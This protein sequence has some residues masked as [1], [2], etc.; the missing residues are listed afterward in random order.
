MKKKLDVK[1]KKI[2]SQTF[3]CKLSE[4]NNKTS[5]HQ[6]KQWDSISH[7]LLISNLE[8]AFKIK[9]LSGEPETMVS[10]KIVLT[11]IRSHEK[12]K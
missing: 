8:K 1:V 7:Y 9:F 6:L 3:N 12:K 5:I 11:T 10:L 2:M 4:L